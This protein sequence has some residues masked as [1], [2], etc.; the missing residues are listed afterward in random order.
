MLN[1]TNWIRWAD[2]GQSGEVLDA[3]GLYMLAQFDDESPNVVEIVPAIIYIGIAGK[4]GTG[5]KTLEKRLHQFNAAANGSPV[6]HSGGKKYYKHF[7]GIQPNLYVAVSPVTQE[8]D[9]ERSCYL[10]MMERILIWRYV[11]KFGGNRP[12]CNSE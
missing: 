11:H 8:K 9:I 1:F 12:F 2:R 4:K 10:L 7:G 6:P 5:C 3:K